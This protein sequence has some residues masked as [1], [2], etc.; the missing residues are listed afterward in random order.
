MKKFRFRL[1]SLLVL[2]KQRENE[3]KR[4]VGNLLSEI[5]QQQQE[6]LEMAQAI[7]T[8]GEKL[9]QQHDQ[10]QIDLEWM[11]HYQIYVQHLQL[12]ISKRITKIAQIQQQL[13]A[14]REELAQAAKEAKILEKLKEKQKQRYEEQLR[15]RETIEQDEIATNLYRRTGK[16][17]EAEVA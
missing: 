7:K 12:S 13:A 16:I 17:C 9:K 14:A 4:V 3:K 1:Q 5:H 2:K 15:R 11:G 6:A 8:E 10:K